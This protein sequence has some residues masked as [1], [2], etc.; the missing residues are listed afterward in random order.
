MWAYS[1]VCSFCFRHRFLSQ[2]D[3]IFGWFWC[4]ISLGLII[5]VSF[6]LS[7]FIREL[8]VIFWLV[9]VFSSRIVVGLPHLLMGGFAFEIL[10]DIS[11]VFSGFAPSGG[12]FK[13][14]IF[15]PHSIDWFWGAGAFARSMGSASAQYPSGIRTPLQGNFRALSPK[16]D[17][18]SVCHHLREESR[19]INLYP[20]STFSSTPKV[21]Q[22]YYYCCSCSCCYYFAMWVDLPIDQ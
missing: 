3:C 17:F 18:F 22:K 21:S 11:P 20:C 19:K 1:L 15:F 12:V 9:V 7:Y 14:C 13:C 16:P 10:W 4:W 6:L 2:K 8:S 5:S